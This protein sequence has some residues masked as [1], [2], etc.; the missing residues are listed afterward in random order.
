MY[1][2]PRRMRCVEVRKAIATALRELRDFRDTYHWE[3]SGQWMAMTTQIKAIDQA[4]RAPRGKR[5]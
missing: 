5:K 1:A 2:T 4:T 3:S